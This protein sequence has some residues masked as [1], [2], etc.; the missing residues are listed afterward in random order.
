MWLCLDNSFVSIIQKK[1]D[2]TTL[3]VRARIKGDLK[4]FF[5][6]TEYEP[7]VTETPYRDYLYRCKSPY[8]MVARAM[9]RN[10]LRS[11]DTNVNDSADKNWH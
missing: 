11:N 7:V 8:E 2:P 4:N 1:A 3:I 10:L 5:G 6:E 9:L